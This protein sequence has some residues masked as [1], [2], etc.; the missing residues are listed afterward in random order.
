MLA[1]ELCAFCVVMMKLLE[2]T[3][4]TAFCNSSHRSASLDLRSSS[5]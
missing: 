2:A 5:P 4:K 1:D 3:T